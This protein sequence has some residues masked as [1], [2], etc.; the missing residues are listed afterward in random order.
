MGHERKGTTKPKPRTSM[1]CSGEVGG[2]LAVH[3]LYACQGEGFQGRD[4]RGKWNRQM[5]CGHAVY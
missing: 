1:S 4:S 5:P 3:S 2:L